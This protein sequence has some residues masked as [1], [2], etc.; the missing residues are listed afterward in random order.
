MATPSD[1]RRSGCSDLLGT[2]S[3]TLDS[4][5]GRSTTS[6][7]PAAAPSGGGA[8]STGPS[9]KPAA[10]AAQG[11]PAASPHSAGKTTA[12]SILGRGGYGHEDLTEDDLK[13]LLQNFKDLSTEEQH[14]LIVYLKK[15]E[16]TDM[17]RVEKL[18]KFV[19]LG[20]PAGAPAGAPGGAPAPAGAPASQSA[21]QA[22]PPKQAEM[23]AAAAAA[24]RSEAGSLSPFSLRLGG[25]NPTRDNDAKRAQEDALV[26][27][28][29][30][31]DDSDDDYTFED[32]Y[33]AASQKVKEKMAEEERIAKER[34]A[35]DVRVRE[36]REKE[37]L[38]NE[39][40][41]RREKEE[42]ERKEKEEREKWEAERATISAAMGSTAQ[43]PVVKPQM[44]HSILLKQTTE[45]LD[46][47]MGNLPS[48]FNKQTAVTGAG[49][50][51]T[52]G[53][54]PSTSVAGAA[55]TAGAHPVGAH[56][57]GAHP[58][59]G[60]GA[61]DQPPQ[62]G[63]NPYP[64]YYNNPSLY[65]TPNQA[66]QGP[67]NGYNNFYNQ[68]NQYQQPVVYPGQQGQNLSNPQ[69]QFPDT[70][71]QNPYNPRVHSGY[72]ANQPQAGMY[73]GQSY[74]N[75]SNYQ[76]YN[77]P[78]QMYGQGYGQQ[79]YPPQAGQYG[80]HNQQSYY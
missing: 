31:L 9:G 23:K 51:M 11:T 20:P 70:M 64:N 25:T 6:G 26:A 65:G 49:A 53:A 46:D 14:G 57:V 60:T 43:N 59:P 27:K 69:G 68:G 76:N 78:Q 33:A 54:P 28:L 47:L 67:A 75:T 17:D 38:V 61:H 18:R 73:Q 29:M 63:V 4:L 22:A 24:P 80:Q 1:G 40:Q 2:S 35:E 44:D 42:R 66:A 37:R 7:A 48:R 8:S 3:D 19:N 41:D 36:E 45:V 72:Y 15:L 30:D 12:A 52:V 16:A 10:G 39:E 71:S 55:V 21:A 79:M 56:P 58:V 5:D 34:R 13:M 62:T 32:V 77:N 50:T 74:Q